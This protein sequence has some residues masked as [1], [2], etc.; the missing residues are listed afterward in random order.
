M[1]NF[2]RSLLCSVLVSGY[3]VGSFNVNYSSLA[4]LGYSPP[5]AHEK[6]LEVDY[7]Q[8]FQPPDLSRFGASN[9]CLIALGGAA[10]LRNRKKASSPT[11]SLSL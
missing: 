7:I 3:I 6:T 2:K 4:G 8:S 1:R 5:G 9:L 11:Q 10:L